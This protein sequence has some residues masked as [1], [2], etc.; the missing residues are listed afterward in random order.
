MLIQGLK[1]VLSDCPI[2]VD[3]LAGQVSSHSHLPDR[4][5]I[6]QVKAN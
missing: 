5:G 1:K 3:F 4:Q 2:Q 6:R